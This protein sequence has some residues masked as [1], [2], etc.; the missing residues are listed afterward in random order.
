MNTKAIKSLEINNDTKSVKISWYYFD[1]NSNETNDSTTVFNNV[2][3]LNKFKAD[4]LFQVITG[5][6]QIHEA[7]NH[8][9]ESRLKDVHNVIDKM[10]D[11]KTFNE[12]TKIKGI[13]QRLSAFVKEYSSSHANF[14]QNLLPVFFDG[15]K[16]PTNAK[17]DTWVVS[18]DNNKLL[19]VTGVEK[20]SVLDNGTVMN[21][22]LARNLKYRHEKSD[23]QLFIKNVK[24]AN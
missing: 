2:S 3:S 20:N 18:D 21:Y 14:L 17:E 6:L 9:W 22:Y 16:E 11:F 24:E 8:L 12:E 13:N 5:S 4:V 1:G 19:S 10:D 15:S 7:N 23:Y